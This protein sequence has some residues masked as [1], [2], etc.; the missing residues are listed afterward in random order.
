MRTFSGY[1]LC[2]TVLI[3]ILSYFDSASYSSQ[4][5]P[6]VCSMTCIP[7]LRK[8]SQEAKA[9]YYFVCNTCPENEITNMTNKV[10]F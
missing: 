9:L 2:E 5:L 8:S 7:G 10:V 6:S 4:I 1:L 3:K